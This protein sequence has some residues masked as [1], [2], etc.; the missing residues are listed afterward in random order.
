MS[1][2]GIQPPEPIGSDQR[3]RELTFSTRFRDAAILSCRHTQ[4]RSFRSTSF[5]LRPGSLESLDRHRANSKKTIR[6]LDG[7]FRWFSYERSL[8]SRK[9][10]RAV[11]PL[12]GV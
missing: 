4:R 3:G 9:M 8:G 10:T 6:A 12:E 11:V 1:R 2:E 7:G 5:R